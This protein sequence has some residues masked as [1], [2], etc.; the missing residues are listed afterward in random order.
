MYS[1]FRKV[2]IVNFRNDDL[3]SFQDLSCCA[4]YTSEICLIL[5]VVFFKLHLQISG[6]MLFCIDVVSYKPFSSMASTEEKV[7][8]CSK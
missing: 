7:H 3:G 1:S 8:Q 4:I 2:F 6:N 5:S